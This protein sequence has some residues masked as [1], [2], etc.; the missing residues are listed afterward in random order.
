MLCSCGVVTPATQSRLDLLAQ[1]GDRALAWQAAGLLRIVRVH[2]YANDKAAGV[3]AAV[4]PMCAVA[5]V[6]GAL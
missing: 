3:H 6:H 1:Y 2:W 4:W 5:V